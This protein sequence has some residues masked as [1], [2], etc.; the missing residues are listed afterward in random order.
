MGL[1]ARL[2]EGGN[3]I[4]VVTHEEDVAAYAHRTNQPPRR[5]QIEKDVRQD[6]PATIA[7]HP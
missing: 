3:T 5:L 6:R 7:T 1:F 4:V 2:H